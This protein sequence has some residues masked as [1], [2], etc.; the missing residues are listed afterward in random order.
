MVRD[1]TDMVFMTMGHDHSADAFLVLAQERRVRQHHIH[2]V[3]SVAWEGQ[4]GIH[5]H[6]VVAVLENTGV[7]TDLMQTPQRN[8]PQTRVLSLPGLC[9]VNHEKR[10][11]KL[12]CVSR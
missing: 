8:H 5:E 6:Q 11:R 7:L 3:H 12:F 2:A 4:T 9:V 10:L 1:A